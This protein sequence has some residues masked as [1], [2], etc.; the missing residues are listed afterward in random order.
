MLGAG[1]ITGKPLFY[2]L[3]RLTRN[4]EA[5]DDGEASAPRSGGDAPV[6]RATAQL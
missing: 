2:R 3:S 5:V 1:R 6:P 4:E